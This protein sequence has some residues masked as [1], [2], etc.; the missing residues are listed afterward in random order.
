MFRFGLSED[1]EFR[2]RWDYASVD[3]EED[4]ESGAENLR[5]SF[6]FQITEQKYSCWLRTSP[7]LPVQLLKG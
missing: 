4:D 3:G 5:W 7:A 6:K 1:I 2:L